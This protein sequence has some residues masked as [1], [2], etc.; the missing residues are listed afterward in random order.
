M[1]SS[2]GGMLWFSIVICLLLPPAEADA[3]CSAVPKPRVINGMSVVRG[4][5]PWQ[6]S[7]Q[8]FSSLD[9]NW[10]HR[11]GGVLINRQWVLSAA[12]CVVTPG[13]WCRVA[14]GVY[15]LHQ[16]EASSKIREADARI[17]HPLYQD[18]KWDYDVGLVRLRTPVTFNTLLAPIPLAS[19]EDFTT[20]DNRI[21]TASG[22][23]QTEI[24]DPSKHSAIL[25]KVPLRVI[26]HTNCLQWDPKRVYFSRRTLCAMPVLGGTTCSGDSG[27][28]L[29]CFRGGRYWLVGIVS[30]GVCNEK[31]QP[32][33]F[34]RVSEFLD[35][36]QTTIK[37]YA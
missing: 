33:A 24:N 2:R 17:P 19:K 32:V 30:F 29:Q 28:P 8:F 1:P 36:I 25:K 21:C 10:H 22:W 3:A 26:S 18:D 11:C 20:F 37:Q 23:G 34:A 31:P 15:N 7:L 9:S 4:Q 14:L 35:W 12:H 5:F 13:R 27:G 6:V 16:R